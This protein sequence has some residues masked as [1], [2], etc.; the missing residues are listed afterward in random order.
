[1]RQVNEGE[2]VLFVG[3]NWTNWALKDWTAVI[4]FT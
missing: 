1:M 3:A 4:N 2:I